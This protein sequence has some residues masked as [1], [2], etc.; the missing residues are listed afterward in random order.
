MDQQSFD[1]LVRLLGRPG[2]RRAALGGFLGV[3]L[4]GVADHAAARSKGRGKGEKRVAAAAKSALRA[5][6]N[7]GPG[8]NLSN[9][10]FQRV[11]LRGVSLSG[12]NL[13][14]AS[15]ERADLR[16]VSLR[17][18]NLSRTNL[19]R[20]NLCAAKLNATN[21]QKSDLT[22]ALLQ[23]ADLRGAKVTLS[24]N[25]GPILC[26]TI[27]PN[28]KIDNAHCP[29]E[30][31]DI[32]CFDVDCVPIFGDIPRVCNF[33]TCCVPAGVDI[34]VLPANFCCSGRAVNDICQ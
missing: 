33:G 13:S 3:G 29:I 26:E 20:A 28:G 16:G 18:A 23:R 5:C 34:G 2:S 31:L 12:A 9:C 14:G 11:D 4:M 19:V 7:P 22:V 21:L 30:P 6:P 1:R 24:S 27:L 15:L 32:C 25:P 17:G 8:K 10:D